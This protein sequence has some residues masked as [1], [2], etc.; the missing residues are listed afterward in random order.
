VNL[1]GNLCLANKATGVG[2]SLWRNEGDAGI[3]Q[4]WN[5]QSSILIVGGL[6]ELEFKEVP[7]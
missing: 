3:S 6:S 2:E 4:E 7:K 1:S 5:V